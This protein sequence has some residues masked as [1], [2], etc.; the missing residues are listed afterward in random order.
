MSTPTYPHADLIID[1]DG[2][3]FDFSGGFANYLREATGLEPLAPEPEQFNYSDTYPTL[4]DLFTHIKAFIKSPHFEN[5]LF[6]PGAADALKQIHDQGHRI[7]M[8]TSCGKDD[9]IQRARRA[10]IEREVGA[11]VDDVIFLD[12]GGSKLDILSKV[13]PSTFVDDQLAM[14]IEGAKAG[15]QSYLFNRRYNQQITPQELAAHN[16]Y[17]AYGWNC[18]PHIG[19]DNAPRTPL[20]RQAMHTLS[21]VLHEHKNADLTPVQLQILA[22][23]ALSQA[24]LHVPPKGVELLHNWLQDPIKHAFPA[25]DRDGGM[26]SAKIAAAVTPISPV[27]IEPAADLR[28][29]LNRK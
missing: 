6:Y 15:H 3:V 17:R 18:L 4:T 22:K 20:E 14:C 24:P 12:L 5:T 28:A 9:D 13:P 25:L 8:V 7:I 16:I 21:S 23:N 26:L 29:S 11:V 10:G 27:H 1:G 19:H 2:V